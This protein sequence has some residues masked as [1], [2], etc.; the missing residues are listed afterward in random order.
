MLNHVQQVY[1]SSFHMGCETQS[2]QA[3]LDL[4]MFQPVQQ[5]QICSFVSACATSAQQ[6]ISCGLYIRDLDNHIGQMFPV[7]QVHINSFHMHCNIST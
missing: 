4:L 3:M 1:I 6:L 2:W 5:A 7:Q